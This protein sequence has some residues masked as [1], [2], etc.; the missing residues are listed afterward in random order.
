MATKSAAQYSL[1]E[2]ALSAL[3]PGVKAEQVQENVAWKL[4]ARLPLNEVELP[5]KKEISLLREKLDP[6][7]LHIK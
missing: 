1:G 3:Y 5:T 2:L 4:A 7:R 6:K